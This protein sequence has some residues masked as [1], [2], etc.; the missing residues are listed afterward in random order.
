L[1][2]GDITIHDEFRPIRKDHIPGKVGLAVNCDDV[3]Y[4]YPLGLF[5]GVAAHA[6]VFGDPGGEAGQRAFALGKL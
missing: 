2:P 3:R 5:D 1:Q 4:Q 6:A